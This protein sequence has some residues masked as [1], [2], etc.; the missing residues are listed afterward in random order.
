MKNLSRH[1]R[2]L[3]VLLLAVVVVTLPEEILMVRTKRSDVRQMNQARD[4]ADRW[5]S[6]IEQEKESRGIY[7]IL[8]SNIPHTG[9]LGDEFTPVTT[10]LGS[11]EAK[12][13]STNPD[14]AALV[15]RLL[16]EAGI[17]SGGKAG[18]TLS[19]SFPAL[20]IATLAAL[21]TLGLEVTLISSLGASSY[22][23]NQP[24]ALWLDYENW[25]AEQ[26]GLRYRSEIVTYGSEN[27]NGSSVYPDGSAIM[28]S[29]FEK[30]GI[31]PYLP[32]SLLEAVTYKYHL[33]RKKEIDVLINIG[34]NQASLGSCSHSL[35][36]PP[37]LNL[38]LP[39]CNHENRGLILEFSA[40][41]IPVIQLLNIRELA[42]KYGIHHPA[43]DVLRAD[44]LYSDYRVRKGMLILICIVLVF[45]MWWIG[46]D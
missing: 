4:L 35:L 45:G 5:M 43:R 28:D 6:I 25:L 3:L 26:G 15:V 41:G 14:F 22:G 32:Q 9:L 24:G 2:L 17:Q 7:N 12:E 10:T 44:L 40:V 21:Q 39:E 38:S 23:A 8:E 11:P 31:I 37:G 33:L 19:G 16:H 46:K 34:G 29:D 30:Y 18:V 20:G 36:I 1:R 13:L 27:D 42:L